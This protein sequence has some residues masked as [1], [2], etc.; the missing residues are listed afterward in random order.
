[1][2]LSLL[3]NIANVEEQAVWK[4]AG[5][6]AAFFPLHV[7]LF[8]LHQHNRVANEAATLKQM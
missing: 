5:T 3:K 7:S 6:I 4:N 1:M 8:S 2:G